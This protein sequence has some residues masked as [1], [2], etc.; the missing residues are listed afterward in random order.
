MIDRQTTKT[1][2]AVKARSKTAHAELPG[3][4]WLASTNGPMNYGLFA[5]LPFRPLACSPP[6][7]MSNY[8]IQRGWI[9]QDAGANQPGGEKAKGRKSQKANKPEG[10]PAKGRKSQTP[11]L[12]RLA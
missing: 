10:E 9:V 3:K 1:S 4:R 11:N 7:S 5:P 2:P 6:G 12:W 8:Y